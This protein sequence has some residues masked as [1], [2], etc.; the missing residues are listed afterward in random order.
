MNIVP[1][2]IIEPA[3]GQRLTGTGSV[4]MSGM[5]G[6]PGPAGL[7]FKWYSSL[8]ANPLGTTLDFT[9][10]LGVGSQIITFSAKDIAGDAP[11]DIQRVQ[12][13]GMAGGPAIAQNPCI[14]HVF[15]A[16]IV[17]PDRAG[18]SVTK[19]APGLAA[20]APSAWDKPD[21][22]QVNRLRYRWRFALL[23]APPGTP[24]TEIA[25]APDELEFRPVQAGDPSGTVPQLRY[26]KPLPAALAAGN[27][28]LT[29]RVED[30][31]EPAIGTDASLDILV[32][33]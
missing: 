7:F 16:K 13:A 24:P 6:A 2:Q 10:N 27:H 15:T 32:I 21:Y 25:P 26:T 3:N 11:A 31:Q 5:V 1:L 28:R 18:A 8:A 20:E 33:P 23:G 19:A 12:R 4:H 29:L 22:R 9:T 30:A 17:R 14:L